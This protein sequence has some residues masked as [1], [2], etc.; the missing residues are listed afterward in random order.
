[1][2]SASPLRAEHDEALTR[3]LDRIRP[4]IA[5]TVDPL[6]VAALLESD[7]I[8]DDAARSGYGHE[9]VFALATEV[10]ARCVASD[11]RGSGTLLPARASIGAPE[12]VRLLGHGVLYLLPATL[13]PP[14]LDVL[15]TGPVVV[16]LALGAAL[17]WV[18]AGMST[19]VAFQLLS[20]RGA[21]AADRLLRAAT[22]SGLGVTSLVA[23][24]LALSVGS[25]PGLVAVALAQMAYQM[26]AT[27]V[28]FQRR[29]ALL[30]AAMLPGVGLGLAHVLLP[31]AVP[32]TVALCAGGLSVLLVLGAALSPR[33][34]AATAT[35]RAVVEATRGVVARDGRRL[36]LVVLYTAL[37]AAFLLQ[38]QVRYLDGPVD[39]A[40]GL[41]PLIVG[42]G[43]VELRA[44][45]FRDRATTLMRSVRFPQDF[46]R[47]MRRSVLR[48]LVVVASTVTVLAVA[49]RALLVTLGGSSPAGVAVAASGVLLACAYYLSFLMV[50]LSLLEPLCG[51]V[52]LALVVHVGAVLLLPGAQAL[53][54]DTVL[55]AASSAL[56]LVVSL[57]ALLPSVTDPRAF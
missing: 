3:L 45:G 36:A 48:D 47:G 51:A 23:P 2:R 33:G 28:M 1:M 25:E 30:V 26:S 5:Q 50:G 10:R 39:V 6:Q 9:D 17:A 34:H 40:V 22:L 16:G 14:V 19:W 18:W 49:F 53:L 38:A 13:F 4:V 15:G 54:G 24:V 32:T 57:A 12:R 20:S 55:L 21:D 11:P 44:Q 27:V 46:A 37:T 35:A 43:V 8:T 56:L 7:G 42:M 29:E 52:A 41:L 31:A